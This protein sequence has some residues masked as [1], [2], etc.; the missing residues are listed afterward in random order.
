MLGRP[1]EAESDLRA[2]LAA[3]REIGEA[4]GIAVALVQL[5]DFATLRADYATVIACLE[6]A[7]SFGRELQAWGDLAHIGGKLAAI[8][9][10]MGD[11]AAARA[12][13]E[14]AERDEAE[15]GTRQS[16]AAVWLGLVRAQLHA[17]EGDVDGAARQCEKVLS[18]LD[19]KPS[20][21]WL[22]F[23]AL[24]QARL[25]LILLGRGEEP[26][27]RALLADA[28]RCAAEWVERPALA[29]VIDATAAFVLRT[30]AGAEAALLAATLLGAAH[31]VRGAFDESS[32]DAPA[33][34]DAARGVLGA[35]GFDDAY[36]RGRALPRDE[37]VTLA[38]SGVA[39]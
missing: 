11:L 30:R 20:P 14:R 37:A 12:D 25:A 38:A 39:P 35:A 3:F 23:R 1:A 33:A 26:R 24:T 29:E 16:D 19:R 4:W 34:R 27:C 15:R 21:W 17:R 22:G 9:L 13:V 32:L 31:T 8:R 6:E 28:L 2:A 36:E 7:A 5:A 18:W 10:R